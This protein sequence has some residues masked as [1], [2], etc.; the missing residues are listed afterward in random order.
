M[1]GLSTQLIT[2]GKISS[3]EGQTL[4]TS[5]LESLYGGRLALKKG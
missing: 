4:E 5:T 3:D 2:K 1:F